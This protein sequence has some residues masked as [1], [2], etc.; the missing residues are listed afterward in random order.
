M[1]C[2]FNLI[3]Q[4]FVIIEI[5]ASISNDALTTD[6][7]SPVQDQP[8]TA[9]S[10][11]PATANPPP[12]VRVSKTSA[13]QRAAVAAKQTNN[14]FGDRYSRSFT[15]SSKAPTAS[16]PAPIRRVVAAPTSAAAP[17]PA[18]TVQMQSTIATPA[19]EV[20]SVPEQTVDVVVGGNTP[21]LNDPAFRLK[22]LECILYGWPLKQNYAGDAREAIEL[23][24]KSIVSWVL[25][26]SV[27]EVWSLKR[28]GL[29]LLG[30]IVAR[31][32]SLLIVNTTSRVIGFLR[33]SFSG[34]V[35][36]SPVREACL[37]ALRT[38]CASQNSVCIA[39]LNTEVSANDVRTLFVAAGADSAPAVLEELQRVR[40]AWAAVRQATN[41]SSSDI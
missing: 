22:A 17:V 21:A 41:L 39:A 27:H 1:F 30:T 40:V 36:H 29:L 34:N 16:A 33:S 13:A 5:P 20:P 14:M 23:A 12:P 25:K 10:T 15:S 7:Q 8:A 3:W 38:L 11:A 19:S 6:V 35:K 28:V 18:P 32:E 4:F 37:I 26:S 31:S 2:S 9:S 24:E